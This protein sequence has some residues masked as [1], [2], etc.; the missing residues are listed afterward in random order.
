MPDHFSCHPLPRDRAEVAAV[1]TCDLGA[2]HIKGAACFQYPANAFDQR[3]VPGLAKDDHIADPDFTRRAWKTRGQDII[4][5]M[6]LRMKAVA[7]DL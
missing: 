1:S 3:T 4:S 6:K 7:A 2:A 5:L